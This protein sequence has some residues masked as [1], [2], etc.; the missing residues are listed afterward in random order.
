MRFA[1]SPRRGTLFRRLIT[2]GAK[3]CR[4]GFS[5]GCSVSFDI[6]GP[7]ASA[8][9][10]SVRGGPFHSGGNGLLFH[11]N[12]RNTLVRGLG[13]MSTSI[14]FIGGVSGIIPS[15]FGYSAI[16]FGG[17]VTNILISLRR[18]VFG[19][20]R[21]VSDNGCSRSRIRRVVRFLRRR[22][23]IGG[24]RAGLLRSTRL[25]LCVGDG[26]GHP[27]HIYNVIG[28]I[29]RPNNNPFLTIGPSKAISLRVLRDSRVSLGSPRGG[30]VFRGN[31][32][33]GP[34]SLMYT[35]GGCGNR[36]FGL[37][38]CM[39]GG[40]NFVSCGDGSNHRLGT[41]RLPNL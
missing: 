10:T 15:D 34:I 37:P 19:C 13:S 8:V 5:I 24:P 9:T 16:V 7:D 14:I 35:L 4:R 23:Y 2:T 32:R 28:G 26:L 40:A 33:F 22:L 17:I 18:H 11:P 41:L 21:L 31:A 27:L 36:G 12:N 6:R 29:N 38:S 20:L 3:S 25:V 1:I 39:S 30:T